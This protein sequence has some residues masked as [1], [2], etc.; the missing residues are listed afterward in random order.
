MPTSNQLSN[1]KSAIITTDLDYSGHDSGLDTPPSTTQRPSSY[2]DTNPF[3]H[4]HHASPRDSTES[5]SRGTLLTQSPR[6]SF[7]GNKHLQHVTNLNQVNAL[8]GSR[9]SV[10]EQRI[11]KIRNEERNTDSYDPNENRYY[12]INK[13]NGNIHPVSLTPQHTPSKNNSNS[14]HLSNNNG[15]LNG[16]GNGSSVYRERYQHP[17]LAAI[18]NEA[19]GLKFRGNYMINF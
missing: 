4:H 6:G 13:Q 16:N 17:A 1:Q 5:S 18:I 12:N 8:H 19:Q 7:R 15:T 2:R 3:H 14:A 9:Y 10:Q 11:L